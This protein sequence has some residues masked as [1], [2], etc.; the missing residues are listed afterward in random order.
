MD[1]QQKSKVIS[2]DQ[3]SFML[4]KGHLDCQRSLGLNGVDFDSLEALVIKKNKILKM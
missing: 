1:G 3:R 2:D 4:V